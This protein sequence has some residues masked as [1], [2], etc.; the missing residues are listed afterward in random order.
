MEVT[1]QDMAMAL[2]SNPLAM[3]QAKVMALLRES[4]DLS[5]TIEAL[6]KE[7]AEARGEPDA[8]ISG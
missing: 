5:D 6:E 8:S 4:R 7:L 3:E 2:Q 1:P